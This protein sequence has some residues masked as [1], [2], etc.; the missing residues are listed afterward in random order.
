MIADAAPLNSS[1]APSQSPASPSA[2]AV[3]ADLRARFPDAAFL[4]LGQTA[5]WDEA[6]KATLRRALDTVWP[7]ARLVAA[8]HDTD[9]FAKLPGH[10]AA[11]HENARYALVFH[12]DAR[13]RGLWS[14]AGEMSRLFGSEDVPTQAKLSSEGGVVLH[15]ALHGANNNEERFLLGELTAA[16]GWTG[17]IYTDWDK[18]VVRDVPLADILPTL[19]EQFDWAMDGTQ[20]CLGGE[21]ATRAA[22][23]AAR[24]RGWLTDFARFSPH[25]SLSDLYR[26]LLPRFYDLLL[27]APA[28][29]LSTSST[30]ALLRFNTQTAPLP[31]F[32][33]LDMFLNPITRRH[34]LDAYN[35]AVGGSDTY[36]LDRFGDG[37][38]PFDLVIPGKGRG[39]IR[40]PGDGNIFVD[41]PQPIT[42]CDE[43]CDFASVEKLAALVERELGPD[44]AL[45]GKAVALVPM[46]CAEWILVFHEGASGYTDRTRNMMARLARRKIPL[47]PLH[48]ILRIRYSTWDA[49]AA[50]PQTGDPDTDDFRLPAHL[51]QAFGRERISV[52]DFALCWRRPLRHETDR[53]ADLKSLTS[54]RHLLGYLATHDRGEMWKAAARDYAQANMRLL[55]LRDAAQAIQGR[56]YTMYDQVRGLKAEA[57]ALEKRKGDDF[58]AR[59]Q[60]LRDRLAQTGDGEIAAQIDAMQSER[61]LEYD[62]EIAARRGQIRF[63]LA[64]VRELKEKRLTLERGDE[65]TQA[66][67]D[68]RRIEARAEQEKARL[69]R[70]ALQTIHGLPHTDFRPSSWW[71]PLVDESGA[72]FRRLGETAEMSLEPL[73][74][75]G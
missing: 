61:A 35:L 2:A 56:V 66:R 39:T 7:D 63:A 12:D 45:V 15:R 48:P 59:V 10:G 29:N 32:A 14:A 74:A 47:P 27:G 43:G 13:T 60:P 19:L 55:Y 6:S 1:F 72:W 52:N 21:R 46:L 34:A 26:D 20:E 3:L 16:W 67:A 5:L 65:A 17:I 33:F 50:V 69:V 70:N 71:F 24:I 44:V 49:L 62:A 9:Y 53:L 18:K 4:A 37:A 36:T 23:T 30:T 51:Q 68:L 41:T 40:I 28:H 54:P 25:A 42:L 73:V 31:R 57:A 38:I 64:T 8:V 22:L 11:A 58:R 75:E